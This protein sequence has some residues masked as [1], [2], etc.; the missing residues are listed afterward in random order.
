MEVI[1]K[2]D[3]TVAAV[4]ERDGRFLLIE[5]E[6]DE[7]LRLNQPAGHWEPHESLIAA[8]RRETLEESAYHFTPQALVGVYRY[9]YAPKD[10]TFLRFAFCGEAA[11]HEADRVLDDGIVR[12]VWLTPDEIRAGAAHHRTPLVVR[13]MEDYLAGRR[14]PLELLTHFD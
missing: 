1:W 14:Y 4:I 2:P 13:C 8:T 7:G 3:V 10:T 12:A 11:G 5:E 6:T 9:R